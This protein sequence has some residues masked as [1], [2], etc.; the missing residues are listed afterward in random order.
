MKT[1]DQ[2]KDLQAVELG[3]KNFDDLVLNAKEGFGIKHLSWCVEA[4]MREYAAIEV[5]QLF[6]DMADKY[7]LDKK[8]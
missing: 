3:Y 1:I 8:L 5:F 4:C 7:T 6:K 2:I